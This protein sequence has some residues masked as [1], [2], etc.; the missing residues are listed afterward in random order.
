[1]IIIKKLVICEE[2]FMTDNFLNDNEEV[3]M[4]VT[5]A[6]SHWKQHVGTGAHEVEIEEGDAPDSTQ[7]L[8]FRLR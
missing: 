7:Q 8:L 1:M 3:F 4:V 5:R 2:A 6:S